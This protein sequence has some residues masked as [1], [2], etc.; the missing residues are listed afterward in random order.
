MSEKYSVLKIFFYQKLEKLFSILNSRKK[1]NRTMYIQQKI[2]NRGFVPKIVP[3]SNIDVKGDDNVH[4][5]KI[6][7]L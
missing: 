5:K 6:Y 1:K 4:T 3:L 7:P 2:N